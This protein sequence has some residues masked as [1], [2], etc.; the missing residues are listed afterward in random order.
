MINFIGNFNDD[1][2]NDSKVGQIKT[3]KLKNKM[4]TAENLLREKDRGQDNTKG[5]GCI[6]ELEVLGE[7][8]CSNL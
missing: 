3:T 4:K 2:E 6:G 7:V 5:R 8:H 1:V